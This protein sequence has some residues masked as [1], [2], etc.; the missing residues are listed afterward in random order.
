MSLADRFVDLATRP[1][2]LRALFFRRLLRRFPIGSWEMRLRS[3][4]VP[5][6]HYAWC[7]N[8]AAR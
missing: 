7:L 1:V 3:G 5:R 4:A 6:P 8:Y 2:P